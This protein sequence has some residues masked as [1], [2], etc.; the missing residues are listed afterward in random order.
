ML[1]AKQNSFLCLL[2]PP[3]LSHDLPNATPNPIL[4][5]EDDS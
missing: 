5:F 4:G 3:I 2:P 1:T